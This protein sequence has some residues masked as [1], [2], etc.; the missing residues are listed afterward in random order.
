MIRDIL[1]SKYTLL[2]LS[3]FLSLLSQFLIDCTGVRWCVYGAYLNLR[4]SV[5]VYD[6]SYDN[7]NWICQE[8]ICVLSCAERFSDLVLSPKTMR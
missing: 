8:T 3:K 4:L 2:L 1:N 5:I 7:V 6:P